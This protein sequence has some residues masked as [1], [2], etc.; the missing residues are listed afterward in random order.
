MT[1][2][3]FESR[4]APHQLFGMTVLALS[5]DRPLLVVFYKLDY[6][7]MIYIICYHTTDEDLY[8][9]RSFSINQPF[10]FAPL[11]HTHYSLSFLI[12]GSILFSSYCHRF[13]LFLLGI[14]LRDT[15]IYRNL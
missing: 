14:K 2:L 13:P 10:S 4:Y 8:I 6:L 7:Q 9:M 3:E 1:G 5:V 12:R 15:Y 11:R